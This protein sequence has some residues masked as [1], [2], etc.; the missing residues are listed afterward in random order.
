MYFGI[1]I[2]PAK[3]SF[4]IVYVTKKRSMVSHDKAASIFQERRSLFPVACFKDKTRSA[5]LSGVTCISK[6]PSNEKME[7]CG[8]PCVN[9]SIRSDFGTKVI[10][11]T[12]HTPYP[13]VQ[14]LQ[15]SPVCS[16]PEDPSEDTTAVS[17]HS[18]HGR[19]FC[20]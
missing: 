6:S 2:Q 12:A 10:E 14:H 8:T 5:L 11:N 4:N 17:C 18:Q 15:T 20:S 13:R 16:V 19:L 9:V 7:A 1:G 3:T